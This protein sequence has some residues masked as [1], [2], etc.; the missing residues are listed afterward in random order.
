VA[1]SDSRVDVS[2]TWNSSIVLTTTSTAFAVLIWLRPWVR[3]IR[4]ALDRVE[5]VRVQYALRIALLLLCSSAVSLVLGLV[6][7]LLIISETAAIIFG[8]IIMPTVIA[9]VYVTLFV[10]LFSRPSSTSLPSARRPSERHWTKVRFAVAR[11]TTTR[12]L[13]IA[14]LVVLSCM[15]SGLRYDCYQPELVSA[16]T[17]FSVSTFCLLLPINH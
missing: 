1:S 6:A 14:F 13:Y 15:I 3:N 11:L 16:I 5:P 12:L 8:L 4:A 7:H 10:A 2:V 17:L 9:G